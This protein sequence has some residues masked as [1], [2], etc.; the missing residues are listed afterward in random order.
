LATNRGS[1]ALSIATAKGHAAIV[2]LLRAA[3]GQP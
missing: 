1:T 2:Q 3:L